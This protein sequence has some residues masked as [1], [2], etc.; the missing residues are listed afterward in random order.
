MIIDDLNIAIPIVGGWL[1]LTDLD[2]SACAAEP[3]LM[4]Q[5]HSRIL[6]NGY[7][8]TYDLLREAITHIR[9]AASGKPIRAAPSVA[10]GTARPGRLKGRR[11]HGKRVRTAGTAL[12]PGATATREITAADLAWRVIPVAPEII[13]GLADA[14]AGP[15][16][17]EL[18]LQVAELRALLA[19][20]LIQIAKDNTTERQWT[21][22]ELFLT[23]KYTQVQIGEL[24]GVCQTTVFKTI[25][26]ND[27]Y[28]KDG[29]VRRY[30]G[31][32]KKLRK[33]AEADATCVQLLEQIRLMEEA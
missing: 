15:P 12:P 19:E 21:I 27:T 20:R 5:L 25:N 13:A 17:N 33:L 8:L 6:A 24:V 28:H 32:V 2:V 1:R 3:Q 4:L 7:N 10:A 23:G 26:G 31:L 30:G 16:I 18:D 11:L 14:A 9:A 22:L 29:S